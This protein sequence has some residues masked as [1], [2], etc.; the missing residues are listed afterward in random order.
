MFIYYRVS[1]PR[2]AQKEL[3]AMAPQETQQQSDAAFD[4]SFPHA[5]DLRLVDLYEIYDIY[6][7]YY[8]KIGSYDMYDTY[9]TVSYTDIHIYMIC[10]PLCGLQLMC[11]HMDARAPRLSQRPPKAL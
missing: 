7:I 5:S 1:T 2:S 3:N 11:M 8:T 10:S 4:E 6:A 9:N